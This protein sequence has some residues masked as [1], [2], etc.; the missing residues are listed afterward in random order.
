VTDDKFLLLKRHGCSFGLHDDAIREIA[1]HCELIRC[2]SGE[3]VHHAD[4]PFRSVFLLIQGRIKQSLL[5][6]LGNVMLERHQT[7]G[8]QI[9]AL[10]ATLGE[11]APVN[12]VAEEPTTLL[13]LD[14][15][16]AIEL[17]KK[18][19]Q[20]R[21]NFSRLIAD[22]VRNALMKD[23]RQKKPAVVAMFH[24]S[25]RSRLITRKLVKRLKELGENPS[26]LTDQTD[27]QAMDDVPHFCLV[28]DGCHVSDREIRDQIELWSSAKRSFIDVDAAIDF[29]NALTIVESS[30]KIFWC[31][32]PDNWK[33]SVDQL[34]SLESRVP[35][36]RDKINI[37]WF[38]D[39]GS[40]WAP[41]A[42]ELNR[43]AKRNFK[44]SF[45]QPAENRS[46]ELIN[47]FERIVHQLRGLRIGVA[48]GGG[49]AK[50]M[51]H[52]GVLKTLEQNGIFVDMIAGTS[53][54]AMT[55]IIYASGMLPDHSVNCFVKDLTPS[56]LFRYLPSGGYW[57]LFYK[58][59]LGK[60][61]PMLRKYLT[62]IHLQQLPIPVHS[63][64]VDLIAGQ[65]VVRDDGDSVH[66]ITESINLPVLSTPINRDGRALIDG[67]I[68]NNVP[69]D[70]L[71]SKGCNFVIAVS[72]TAQMKT[73][74]ASN[75]AETPT[76]RMKS[77]ST[78]KT[79][80]RTY[81]VQNVNMNSVG[82]E[83]ADFVI[84]PDLSEFDAAEFMRADEMST[85]GAKATLD[86]IP[87]IKELLHQIDD[88][89]FAGDDG[90]T[91]S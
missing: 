20:F 5:D 54:G 31:V 70:V 69:A 53:A 60:F 38:L 50:G 72:V 8:G 13:R 48:L 57:Y 78:L 27:W 3:Y 73:V 88:Q 83:P 62:D 52:L 30:E 71:V 76:S 87:K 49:A 75:H 17:T 68:V 11:P 7:A 26:V 12:M 33:E 9:G 84:E 81:L 58:Y 55:G 29:N 40:H 82:V 16:T 35:G 37:I 59:R 45:D 44:L 32:T 63:V 19:D 4:Q 41:L 61:D 42:P 91:K 22:S 6:I 80:L 43:L 89:L 18:Y 28:Q 51:A 77:A 10:A 24:Q 66:A 21:L 25:P 64:T 90:P 85:I 56:W 34:A 36:W 67:G 23:R 39:D 86:S 14:Y 15:Q 47:G 1:N 79:I 46:R 74:F 65:A 2:E